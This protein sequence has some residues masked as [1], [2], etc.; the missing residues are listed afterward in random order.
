[1]EGVRKFWIL[2]EFFT[3]SERSGERLLKVARRVSGSESITGLTGRGI[4]AQPLW[5]VA[6]SEWRKRVGQILDFG[7]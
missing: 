3:E 7:W 4:A 1:M 6:G 5:R 2:G